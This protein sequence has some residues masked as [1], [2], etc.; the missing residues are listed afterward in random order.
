MPIRLLAPE[1]SSKIAAGEVVERPASV[2]KELVENSIDAGATDVSVEIRAG[3]TEYIRVAD[4][5]CGI[6]ASEVEYAF[7]RFSTSKVAC[8]DD[9]EAEVIARESVSTIGSVT[10]GASPWKSISMLSELSRP[11]TTYCKS[12]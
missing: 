5:G 9:L 2:V 10:Q 3:G 7:E 8:A 6:P 1:V 11:M 4:N 12:F